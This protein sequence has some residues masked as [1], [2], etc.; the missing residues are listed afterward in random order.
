M[1]TVSQGY[2]H[3]RCSTVAVLN[4]RSSTGIIYEVGH[5]QGSCYIG[6]MSQREGVRLSESGMWVEVSRDGSIPK[7]ALAPAAST[8]A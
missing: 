2:H 5:P 8:M 3:V 1:F 7:M 4:V 6:V